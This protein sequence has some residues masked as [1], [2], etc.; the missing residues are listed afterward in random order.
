MLSLLLLENSS[1]IF[2]KLEMLFSTHDTWVFFAFSF[3][4]DNCLGKE[5]QKAQ[6]FISSILL[7]HC[8]QH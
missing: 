4:E 7:H 5:N 3:P 8:E 6:K 1:Y 2:N